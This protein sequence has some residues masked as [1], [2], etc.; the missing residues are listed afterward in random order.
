VLG[1]LEGHL[2]Q[3]KAEARGSRILDSEDGNNCDYILSGVGGGR[4]RDTEALRLDVMLNS[5]RPQWQRW[6]GP[7]ERSGEN[8]STS[9]FLTLFLLPLEVKLFKTC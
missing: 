2:W 4:Y 7:A 1:R 5:M 6:F 3:W 9:G 8:L